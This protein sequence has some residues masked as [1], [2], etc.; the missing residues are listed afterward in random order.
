MNGEA[1]RQWLIICF[2]LSPDWGVAKMRCPG[3]YQHFESDRHTM[4][5]ISGRLFRTKFNPIGLLH[6]SPGE[7][8]ALASVCQSRGGRA[9][10]ATELSKLKTKGDV[11][12]YIETEVFNSLG[13]I[14]GIGSCTHSICSGLVGF[15]LSTT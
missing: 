12:P 2:A 7:R 14:K 5:L 4:L 10:L 13:I 3:S 15:G 11:G 8:Q 1:A 9:S 6:E